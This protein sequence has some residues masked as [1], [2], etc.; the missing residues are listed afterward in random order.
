[1]KIKSYFSGWK[2]FEIEAENKQDAIAKAKEYCKNHPEY[3][4]GGNYKLN[5]IE[6]IRKERK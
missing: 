5:S 2:Q 4:I 3:G 6:C 1:M